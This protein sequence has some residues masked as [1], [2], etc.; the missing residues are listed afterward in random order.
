[1]KFKTR[2][3]KTPFPTPIEGTF[4]KRPSVAKMQMMMLLDQGD[5]VDKS[6]KQQAEELDI[7]CDVL[8]YCLCDEDGKRLE[9][10]LTVEALK[11]ELDSDE[12]V[13]LFEAL[14]KHLEQLGKSPKRTG[15]T[16]G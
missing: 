2:K 11:D 7:M 1:M 9:D 10:I 16:S 8:F 12:I 6:S 13:V 14:G 5:N 4:L 3:R 15:A